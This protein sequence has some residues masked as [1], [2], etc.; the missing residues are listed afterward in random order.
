MSE[1]PSALLKNKARTSVRLLQL[2]ALLRSMGQGAALVVTSLYL[3]ELGWSAAAI[4]SILAGAGLVRAVMYVLAGEIHALLGAKRYLFLYEGIALAAA[5]AVALTSVPWL[6]AAAIA[7]AGFG[8]GHSGSGGP[9]VPIERAWLGAYAKDKRKA[10]ALCGNQAFYGYAGLG[11]G[12]WIACLYAF[13]FGTN[14][15][16]GSFRLIFAFVALT[17]LGSMGC[18]LRLQ[19]GKRKPKPDA[20]PAASPSPSSSATG[21]IRHGEA[22]AS[23]RHASRPALL[24]IG[25][26]AVIGCSAWLR[27]AGYR[28]ASLVLPVAVFL[29]TIAASNYKLFRKPRNHTESVARAEEIKL[30]ASM[31]SGVTATLTSTVT[32]YWFAARFSVSPGWI[33]IVMGSSYLCAAA[34]ARATRHLQDRSGTMKLLLRLQFIA[35]SL[36]L[37][38][39]LSVSF[40]QAAILE[41]GCTA[42]NLG[43]RGSRIAVMME[44]RGKGKRSLLAKLN[45]LVMRMAAALWPGAFIPFIDDGDYFVPFIVAAAVQLGAAF[46]FRS[47]YRRDEREESRETAA[48]V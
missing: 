14:E 6:L 43:T 8:S 41:I 26:L 12:A 27:H 29:L 25:I 36:L 13:A 18:L 30:L 46:L 16:T 24:V 47:V 44:D 1:R 28:E 40:W 31:L 19:G 42:C 3:R 32:A 37:L 20:A 9:S 5:L 34:I 7:V 22:P 21:E 15:G 39:P 33:G 48:S 10:A 17:T 11:A 45:L 35:F 23:R 4:G 38:L 2:L